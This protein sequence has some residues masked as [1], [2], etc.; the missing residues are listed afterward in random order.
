MELSKM[1]LTLPRYPLEAGRLDSMASWPPTWHVFEK[2]HVDALLA[3]EAAGRPLLIRGEPGTGKSQ[4][5]H[6]AAFM[7]R[8][9]FIP[10]VVDSRTEASDLMWRFDAVARLSDAH[11]SA[12]AGTGAERGLEPHR[13]VQPGPLWWAFNW[14]T[15]E[16]QRQRLRVPAAAPER[17]PF[18]W[19]PA[20]GTV[21]LLDEIDK[22]E[23]EVPN[24]LLEALGNGR[25]SVPLL[26]EVVRRPDDVPAPL[27]VITT[28]DER[29][30]PPAFLRRC[31]VL[32]LQLPRGRALEAFLVKRGR[33]HFPALAERHPAVLQGAA[34]MLR[35]DRRKAR[36]EGIYEPGLSEYLDLLRA[37]ESVGGDPMQRLVDLR[38]FT[39]VK[40]PLIGSP[41]DHDEQDD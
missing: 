34:E 36:A 10:F 35:E 33:L 30:L 9:M 15:A 3:A 25:F 2:L 8:R 38:A 39:F 21:L 24:G 13:Y 27:V 19:T 32:T 40:Q 17:P 23:A 29:E 12:A 14:G 20:Q 28:N 16:T 31:L 5:A 11:L 26:G 7:A 18:D 37:I 1:S 41:A 6:A 4:I 22:A